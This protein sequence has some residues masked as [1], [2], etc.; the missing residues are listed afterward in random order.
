MSTTWIVAA[1]AGRARIFE[2]TDAS[3]PLRE[4][5]SLTNPAARL[6]DSEVYTDQADPKAAGK[7]INN[8]GGPL[9][10]SQYEPNQTFEERNA[11]VFAKELLAKLLEAKQ[12]QRFDKLELIAEPKFLGLLRKYMDKGLKSA[13]S[14]EINKD[15]TH[16]S[17]PQLREQIRQHTQQGRR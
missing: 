7:S 9:P 17:G 15:L 5:E 14:Q 11:E 13:V 8:T 10:T 3:A 16:S 6:R 2:E 4:L 1:D 12:Q